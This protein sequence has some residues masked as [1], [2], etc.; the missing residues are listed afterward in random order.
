MNGTMDDSEA[1]DG[2]GAAHQS[3]DAQLEDG[4]EVWLDKLFGSHIPLAG[5]VHAMRQR[6]FLFTHPLI[7]CAFLMSRTPC[8]KVEGEGAQAVAADAD[9]GAGTK[10]AG[11]VFDSEVLVRGMHSDFFSFV[12]SE[13]RRPTPQTGVGST[14][15][16]F[17][18]AFSLRG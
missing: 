11:A 14:V 2:A 15:L 8:N 6:T 1:G 10:D 7:V 3:R 5:R 17:G 9:L 4:A 18:S 12:R 13:C 16:H